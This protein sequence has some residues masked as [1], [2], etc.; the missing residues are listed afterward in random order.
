[1]EQ[2]GK[3]SQIFRYKQGKS[4]VSGEINRKSKLTSFLF[5]NYHII[6]FIVFKNSPTPG[7]VTHAVMLTCLLAML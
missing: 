1:M 2:L 5:I 6:S 4:L 3:R 7:A